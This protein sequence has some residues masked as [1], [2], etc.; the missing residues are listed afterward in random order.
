MTDKKEY[1]VRVTYKDG[2]IELHEYKNKKKALKDRDD[3]RKMETV[4]SAKMKL[5][6]SL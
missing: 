6:S 4:V 1:V 5:K 2:N 3:F